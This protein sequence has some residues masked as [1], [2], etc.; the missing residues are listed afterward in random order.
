[1]KTISFYNDK[2]GV[3]KTTF[4]ILYASWLRYKHSKKV[5]VIDF[6]KRINK[7]R[8]EELSNKQ[9]LEILDNYNV[10]ESWPIFEPTIEEL[11]KYQGQQ[12]PYSLWI[13]EQKMKGKFNDTDVLIIDMPGGNQTIFNSVYRGKDIGLFVVPTDKSQ[14]SLQCT[15]SL[16]K[17]IKTYSKLYAPKTAI[18]INQIQTYVAYTKYQAV[19]D[20]FIKFQYPILPDMVSF[21]ERM[22]T[23]DKN[24][25]IVST[26]EFPD[27]DK[28]DFRG[29]RDLGIEN[30]FIDI[31]KLLKD[32]KDHVG[33]Q[34]A[35]LSF[36]DSLH[37]EFREDR[38]LTK[39][40]FPEFEFPK[41]MFSEK[42]LS[43]I[44]K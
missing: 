6:N 43:M 8:N 32:S 13:H 42:R 20:M 23:L 36:V 29:S 10:E 4:S 5:S 35:D 3:G 37:K 14:M 7:Y 25:I 18:F 11:T 24:N 15:M 27:W 38:Q 33:T 28:E 39:S 31:T 2:G 34:Q 19:A 40:S 22:K 1:M 9:K 44:Q 21:S 17:L 26:L 41:E 12:N 16:N 30:L